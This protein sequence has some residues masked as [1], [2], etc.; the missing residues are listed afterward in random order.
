M[1]TAGM[2]YY[3]DVD[4]QIDET[5]TDLPSRTVIPREAV[6]LV[7]AMASNAPESVRSIRLAVRDQNSRPIYR[8]SLKLDGLWT[9]EAEPQSAAALCEQ[10]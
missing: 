3:F 9:E 5:G 8:V 7:L 2:R 10:S 4:D 1:R 6:G